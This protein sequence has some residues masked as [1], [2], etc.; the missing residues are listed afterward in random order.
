MPLAQ[1]SSDCGTLGFL[2][3]W[4]YSFVYCLL[5]LQLQKPGCLMFSNSLLPNWF[6]LKNVFSLYVL[7]D[8]FYCQVFKRTDF[9][10]STMSILSL[11]SSNIYFL[12]LEAWFGPFFY[13]PC[14][15]LT[16]S[17]FPLHM[18]H[19]LCI[20]NMYLIFLSAKFPCL[21]FLVLCLLITSYHHYYIFLLLFMH[22]NFWCQTFFKYF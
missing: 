17:C 6:F 8:S 14:L 12:S 2:D 20:Y 19:M 10:S 22:D 11:N 5:R 3:L 9:F 13:L 16:N 1:I 7:L 15:S 21:W 4:L 18:E